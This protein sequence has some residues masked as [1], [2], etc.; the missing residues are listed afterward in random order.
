MQNAGVL[1]DSAKIKEFLSIEIPT[2]VVV[3]L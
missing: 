1:T 2:R 3:V